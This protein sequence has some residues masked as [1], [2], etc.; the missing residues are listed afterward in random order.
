LGVFGFSTVECNGVESIVVVAGWHGNIAL[1][2]L[3][4]DGYVGSVDG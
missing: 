4:A 1:A 3:K 2:E